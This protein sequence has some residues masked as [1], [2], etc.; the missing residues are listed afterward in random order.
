MST[1]EPFDVGA[2]ID[3]APWSRLGILV[4]GLVAAGVI[5]D[6][7]NN[8]LLGMIGP[9]LIPDLGID[10]GSLAWVLAAGLAG[11]ALGT[12]VGGWL[13]DRY[14]RRPA[15]LASVALFGVMTMAMALVGSAE[16]LIACRLVAG[17]GLG[18]LLPNGTALVSEYTPTRLRAMM[19]M[20][21][22]TCVPL[23]GVAAAM[24]TGQLLDSTGWRGLALISG[25]APLLL[26]AVLAALLPESA[27]FLA[28]CPTRRTALDRVLHR[29]GIAPPP[30]AAIAEAAPAAA[31]DKP[32]GDKPGFGQI[33]GRDSYPL[34]ITF[35]FCM[36]SSYSLL[37]WLPSALA[38]LGLATAMLGVAVATFNFGGIVGALLGSIVINRLGSRGPMLTLSLISVAVAAILTSAST[39]L[40]LGAWA[41]IALLALLA[42]VLGVV[43]TALYSVAANIF[44][45]R[46]RAT[47]VGAAV[48]IG[49]IGALLSSFTGAVALELGGAMAFFWTIASVMLLTFLGLV[50]IRRHI[51]PQS[52]LRESSNAGR[53]A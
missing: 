18:A 48:G 32:G 53:G 3:A 2:A 37:S 51:P 34:F 44:P 16:A 47:G 23:G 11:M 10:R 36:I 29:L 39:I 8:Q 6:G 31:G 46:I 42:G 12:A 20:L 30:G 26:V 13:G 19:V 40:S 17:L 28:A 22:M 45:P 5:F 14:G 7:L 27:R 43:Q 9:V 33:G 41:L 35:F 1:A 49:R 4:T 25:A 52:Q 38:Q 24:L 21:V 15:I 50:A